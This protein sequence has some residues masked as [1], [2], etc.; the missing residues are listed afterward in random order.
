MY[1]AFLFRLTIYEI[2]MNALL[3]FFHTASLLY[4][5]AKTFRY[6]IKTNI[7][8]GWIELDDEPGLTNPEEEVNVDDSFEDG[9]VVH[10]DCSNW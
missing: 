9:V 7:F 1:P 5:V 8:A 10:V 2:F 6:Y 3:P 4:W